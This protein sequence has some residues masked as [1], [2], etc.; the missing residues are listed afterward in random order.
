MKLCHSKVIRLCTVAIRNAFVLP[1]GPVLI[2]LVFIHSHCLKLCHKT[3]VSIGVHVDFNHVMCD[4]KQGV[5][6]YWEKKVVI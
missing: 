3:K 6:F 1:S 4:T 2:N 5:Y